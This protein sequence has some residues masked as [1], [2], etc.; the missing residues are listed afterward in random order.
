MNVQINLDKTPLE[1]YYL[2]I[3]ARMQI[4]MDTD[5]T[6]SC[7]EELSEWL[8][9]A[10]FKALADPNRVALLV[11]LAQRG[12]KE[13]TVSDMSCCCPVDLSVVSRHLGVLRD[14]G[15]LAAE[16]RGRE[17]YYTVPVNKLTAILRNLADALEACCPE[18]TCIQR[19][20]EDEPQQET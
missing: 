15:I 13:Q 2:H 12:G 1:A 6:T 19:S 8:T 7:S 3:D 16:K 20:E 17:V 14:A 18:G 9:P 11:H 10:F 4:T 5:K